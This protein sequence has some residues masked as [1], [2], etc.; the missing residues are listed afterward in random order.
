MLW[1]ADCSHDTMQGANASVDEKQD[2]VVEFYEALHAC[3][4]GLHDSCEAG[5]AE[6]RTARHEPWLRAMVRLFQKYVTCVLILGVDGDVAH[7]AS[8]CRQNLFGECPAAWH[9]E[10]EQLRATRHPHSSSLML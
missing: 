1:E 8:N 6:L 3:H 7:G 5:S 10:A 4:H 2:L 9:I